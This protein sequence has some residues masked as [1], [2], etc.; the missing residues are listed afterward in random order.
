[1]EKDE[2]EGARKTVLR[3]MSDGW[4]RSAENEAR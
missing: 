1:M 3:T 2:I 4:T